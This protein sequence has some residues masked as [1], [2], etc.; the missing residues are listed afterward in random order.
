MTLFN[1]VKKQQRAEQSKSEEMSKMSKQ[2]FL[3]MLK[4]AGKKPGNEEPDAGELQEPSSVAPGWDVLK[5]D[6]MVGSSIK[7]WHK[8]ERELEAEQEASEAEEEY[9]S[10]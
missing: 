9:E 3:D 5:D 10:E 2:S 7:E 4:S 6:Y 8:V 1:A